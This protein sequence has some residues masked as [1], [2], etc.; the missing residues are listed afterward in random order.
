V[1]AVTGNATMRV[2][3]AQAGR[4]KQDAEANIRAANDPSGTV[5]EPRAIRFVTSLARGGNTSAH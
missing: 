3:F 1:E 2:I 4:R 5:R